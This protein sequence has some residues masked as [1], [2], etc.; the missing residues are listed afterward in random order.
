LVSLAIPHVF[1]NP[2]LLRKLSWKKVIKMR[3][4][5]L[6]LSEKYYEE[7]EG[8]QKEINNLSSENRDDEAF[9]K[10]CEFCERV[11]LSFRPYSKETGKILRIT[12][13]PKAIGF[14][15][16]IILPSVKL[17]VPNAM[18][19]KVCDIMAISSTAG[20]YIL[21][22]RRHL[23]GFE[24]LENLNR[25]LRLEALKDLM[26]CLMPKALRTKG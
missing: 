17:L 13:N 3:Q 26:T 12:S 2:G 14:L 9:G 10:F 22:D 7:I 21:S 11:A 18:L 8:Y 1:V 25:A 24:Y 4:D 16:G 23:A 5:L 15:N 20:L 19:G 6:P